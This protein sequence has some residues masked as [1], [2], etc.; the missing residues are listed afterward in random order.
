M[1]DAHNN[2]NK[3]QSDSDIEDYE[4]KII[5]S[6]IDGFIKEYTQFVEDELN[7]ENQGFVT[8]AGDIERWVG[9]LNKQQV[10]ES[11]EKIISYLKSLKKD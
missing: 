10:L 7:R 3:N 1:K 2:F 5:N 4:K 6:D 11:K 9:K 8:E